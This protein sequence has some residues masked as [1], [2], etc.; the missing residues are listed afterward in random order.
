MN[1]LLRIS[2][3]QCV[4]ALQ[5]VGFVLRRQHHYHT[6]LR[7]NNPFTQIVVPNHNQLDRGVPRAILRQAGINIEKF[8][9]L[10]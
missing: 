6:V 5:K 8:L 10:L 2:G 9:S 1:K 3:R 7:R 4:D